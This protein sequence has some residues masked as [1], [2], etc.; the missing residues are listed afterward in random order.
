[1]EQ[2]VLKKVRQVQLEIALEIR[3]VCEENDIPYFL[4]HGTFL[5]AVRHGGFIPWDDDMDMG[6]LRRDYEKFCRIAPQKLK[7]EYCLQTWYTEPNYS[8]PF[9]KVMKRGTVYLENK[10]TRRLQE[11]GI[12]V[13]IFPH[14]YAPED[15]VQQKKLV[16]SLL[17]IYRMKLMKSGYKPWM[18][19]DR[20]IWKKRIGYLY[21]QA[22]SL[23]TSQSRLARD[24]DTLAVAVPDSSVVC[25]RNGRTTP[26]YHDRTWVEELADYNFEGVTF[27]GPKNYDK[28]L[29]SLYGDYMELPPEGERENRHQIIEIDFGEE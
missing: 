5:G 4:A 27:K 11:N 24:Y 3:R 12:Y 23:F 26:T 2:E 13:D 6:M 25:E 17:S 9:G 21:Y 14:D 10:K 1:M 8:L 15:P 16:A 7:P 18:E 20:I 19:A 29:S 22:K 28:Y